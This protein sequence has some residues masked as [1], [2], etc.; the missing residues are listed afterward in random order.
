MQ[1]LLDYPV[2]GLFICCILLITM[3]TVGQIQLKHLETEMVKVKSELALYK[4]YYEDMHK[5][6][7]WLTKSYQ[8]CN[9]K[10]VPDNFVKECTAYEIQRIK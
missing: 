2:L 1:K 10:D 7:E 8:D 5:Y 4:A 6:P 9:S 3:N